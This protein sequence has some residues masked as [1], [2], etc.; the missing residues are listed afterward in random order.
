MRNAH[1]TMTETPSLVNT[2]NSAMVVPAKPVI[3]ATLVHVW[4]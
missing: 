1:T 3:G 4:P 2:D